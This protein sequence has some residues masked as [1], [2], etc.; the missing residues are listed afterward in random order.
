MGGKERGVLGD[1]WRGSGERESI[2]FQYLAFKEKQKEEKSLYA[3][4]TTVG[5][6]EE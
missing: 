2:T 5:L 3:K 1:R 6:Y 4:L